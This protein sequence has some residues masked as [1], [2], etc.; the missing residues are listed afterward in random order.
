MGLIYKKNSPEKLV[1]SAYGLYVFAKEHDYEWT[2]FK[3]KP[4][5]KCYTFIRICTEKN[6]IFNDIYKTNVGNNVIFEKI[7]KTTVDNFLYWI[8]NNQLNTIEINN[9]VYNTLCKSNC[10]FNYKIENLKR[11]DQEI[12]EAQKRAEIAAENKRKTVEK[13]QKYCEK[14]K[15]FYFQNGG[16][17]YI[18]K[19]KNNKI[20]DLFRS[21]ENTRTLEIY[22]DFAENNPE[23]KQVEFVFCGDIRELLERI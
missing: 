6:G 7:F 3:D 12:K 1:Y 11:K 14:Y 13:V 21:T 17:N 16:K 10:L 9:L 18:L 15:Y 20:M 2:I 8:I 22:A 4:T 19:P 5:E 23:N